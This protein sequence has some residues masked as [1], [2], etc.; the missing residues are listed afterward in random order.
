MAKRTLYYRKHSRSSIHHSKK[1]EP[2]IRKSIHPKNEASGRK[3][4]STLNQNEALSSLPQPYL[5]YLVFVLIQMGR[6]LSIVQYMLYEKAKYTV[7]TSSPS[8]RV[9][10]APP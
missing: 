9:E 10:P 4:Y 8:T 1:N 3:N 7:T 6:I 2:A 5:L